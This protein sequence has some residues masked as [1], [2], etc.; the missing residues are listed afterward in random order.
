M[1][2]IH[3]IHPATGQPVTRTITGLDQAELDRLSPR[4]TEHDIEAVSEAVSDGTDIA[5]E[6]W[7]AAWVARVGPK[8]AGQVILGTAPVPTAIVPKAPQGPKP[9]VFETRAALVEGLAL[10]LRNMSAA[11]ALR[12]AVTSLEGAT[13]AAVHR[14]RAAE[15]LDAL[16]HLGLHVLPAKATQAMSDAGYDAMRDVGGADFSEDGAHKVL[17][18]MLAAG[19]FARRQGT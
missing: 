15:A 1:T 2:T 17:E 7:L 5:P 18:F 12:P 14:A 9:A 6:T 13:D 11:A 10:E 8:L 19:P 3:L 16:G 4:M